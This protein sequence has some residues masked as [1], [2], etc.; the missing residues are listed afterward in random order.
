MIA[1]VLDVPLHGA[2]IH[3]ESTGDPSDGDS[4]VPQRPVYR[5]YPLET[6]HGNHIS[7]TRARPLPRN[8]LQSLP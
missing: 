2:D 6:A 5:R 4:A 3:L 1:H 7:M 8:L